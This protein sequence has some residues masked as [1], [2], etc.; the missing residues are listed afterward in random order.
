ML[1]LNSFENQAGGSVLGIP[2]FRED[3]GYAYNGGYVLPVEWQSAFSGGPVA[4]ACIGA[5]GVGLIA[6]RFR[7]KITYAV[8]LVLSYATITLEVVAESNPVFFAGKFVNG[9]AISSFATISFSYISEV[10]T[11]TPFA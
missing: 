7:R 3:F 10:R 8:A 5:L 6:D 11:P 9:F 1:I 4:S 2:Q